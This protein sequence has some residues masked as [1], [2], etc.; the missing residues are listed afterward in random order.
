[1]DLDLLDLYGRSSQWTATKIA[2]AASSLNAETPCD[3]WDVRTLINH[4]VDTQKYFAGVARGEQPAF[5]AV[6]PPDVIGDEPLA[7]FEQARQETTSA[8]A[9]PGALEKTGVSLGIASSDL[10]LHGWDL[11]VATNQDA[12]MPEGLPD[13][14]YEL[15]HGR[16][17]DEQRKG[18]FKPEVTVGPDASI[19]DKY[20][21][22]TGRT[23]GI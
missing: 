11:A 14:G 19:Q 9:T 20:L 6:V 23:P 22:Y 7:V 13:V 18:I 1:M 12:T 2:G 10:L 4:V 21:A 17:T 8:F 5:P 16:F 3:E 15:V